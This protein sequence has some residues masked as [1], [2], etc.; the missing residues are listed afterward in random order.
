VALHHLSR[1]ELDRAAEWGLT[2]ARLARNGRPSWR[3]DDAAL[4]GF[5]DRVKRGEL[6]A[7]CE[8]VVANVLGVQAPL[9]VGGPDGYQRPDIPAPEGAT[10]AGW[11]VKA[12]RAGTANMIRGEF[13][14]KPWDL[15]PGMRYV[16][17]ERRRTAHGFGFYVH[18]WIG[19]DDLM[20]FS[21]VK[22][23]ADNR[24]IRV[25]Y[26]ASLERW[27]SGPR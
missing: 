25:C 27:A 22:W 10:W 12:Q 15:H 9:V 24:F 14:L 16:F 7:Q 23:F 3:G 1:G 13:S 19:H 17:V 8:I 26:L 11:S 2:T 6:G 18:G 21:K 4:S 20:R 5:A